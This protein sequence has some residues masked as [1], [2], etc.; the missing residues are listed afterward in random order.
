M[1]TP[2]Y[3]N[4]ILLSGITALFGACVPLSELDEMEAT[5]TSRADSLELQLGECRTQS[6]LFLDRMA[7]I[8]RE[9][10]HLD[11]QN[12]LLAAR[13]AELL[14]P[15]SSGTAFAPNPAPPPAPEPPVPAAE[16]VEAERQTVAPPLIGTDPGESWLKLDERG[17]P[18]AFNPAA[19]PDLDY[20]RKYQEA[21]RQHQSGKDDLAFMSFQALLNA[22]PNDMADNCLYWMAESE[23]RTGRN[24][25]ALRLYSAVLDCEP[26]DKAASALLG[27]ARASIALD[28][29]S[30]ARSDLEA[31]RIRYPGSAEAAQ[32]TMLLRSLR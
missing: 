16:A 25:S 18:L 29:T 15:D 32:A 1:K 9:N 21:L 31:V 11:D 7:A 3:V 8:E 12:R 5:L 6:V 13:L 10:L 19:T 17:R 14:Y 22:R 24:D 4:L 2:K 20:L 26:S 30:D 23:I 28:R 27:R